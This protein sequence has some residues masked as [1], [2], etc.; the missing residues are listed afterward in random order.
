MKKEG[1]IIFA[2]LPFAA[3][4]L[5]ARA[6][7][8]PAPAGAPLCLMCAGLLVA[9]CLSKSACRPLI[10]ILF[11]LLGALCNCTEAATGGP[12]PWKPPTGAM[13]ALEHAITAAGFPGQDSS[14]I[15]TALLTGRRDSLP[16]PVTDVFRR[17]GAS[18]ILALSGLHLGIIYLLIRRLTA[19]LGNSPAARSLRGTLCIAL[20]AVYTAATG[21]SPSTVRALLFL[22]LNE[23]SGALS[24]RRHHPFATLCTALTIQLAVKPSLVESIGFQLSYLAVTGIILIYSRISSWYPGRR[25]IM[26]RIWNGAAMSVS[27]QLFTAPVAWYHFHTLPEYFILTNLLALPLTEAIIITALACLVLGAAGICP[28]FLV[29]A[30]GRLVSLMEF[31]LKVIASL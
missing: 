31:C 20:C 16:A 8:L 28:H 7:G 18:H 30:C 27:C 11:C 17:S 21:A 14:A 4:I 12:M 22:S 1:G 3:G 5:G 19:F 25:A 13:D 10:V 6:F 2:G 9:C 29:T 24:G 15:I 23:I 26:K